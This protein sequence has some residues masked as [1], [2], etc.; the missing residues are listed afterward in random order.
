MFSFLAANTPVEGELPKGSGLDTFLRCQRD[1]VLRLTLAPT[2]RTK[3][4]RGNAVAGDSPGAE[5]KVRGAG[6]DEEEG[7]NSYSR[8]PIVGGGAGAAER[9]AGE[10]RLGLGQFRSDHIRKV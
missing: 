7:A 8:G 5:L 3:K 1:I 6:E 2:R 9:T 4:G 10:A